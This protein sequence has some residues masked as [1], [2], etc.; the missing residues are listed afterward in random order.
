VRSPIPQTVLGV[1]HYRAARYQEAL[2]TLKQAEKSSQSAFVELAFLAM[3]Q[4]RLGQREEAKSTL[5]R[6]REVMKKP[7][8]ANNK[9]AQVFIAEAV[10]LIEGKPP[11]PIKI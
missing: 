10:E 3:T 6:L 5:A 8:W 11:A 9:D 2:K 7:D 4:A 1:A